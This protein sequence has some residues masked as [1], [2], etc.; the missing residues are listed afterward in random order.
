[1]AN[2][3]IEKKRAYHCTYSRAYYAEHKDEPQWIAQRRRWNNA[4]DAT[5]KEVRAAYRATHKEEMAAYNEKNKEKIKR[6]RKEYYQKN[7]VAIIQRTKRI[8]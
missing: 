5:H 6:K 7:R 3:S 8:T 4:Y 2:Y 1:M